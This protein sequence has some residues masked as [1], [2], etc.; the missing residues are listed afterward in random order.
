VTIRQVLQ[1]RSG[2]DYEERYDFGNPGVA[3]R[4][5]E[6]ALVTNQIR[7]ADAARTIRRKHPPGAVWE[8]KT[9]DTAV[10]GWLLERV[11]HGSNLAAFAAQRLW[12][13]LGA[14]HDAFFIMDGPP[15]TGREFSGAGF[16]ATLR[17]LGRVGLMM[18]N[19]GMAGT[20]RRIVSA[21]WVRESTQPTGGPGPGYGYQWW[22]VPDSRAYEALGLQGQYIHVDPETRT[23][24]VKLSY[25]P[26]GRS[27]AEEETAAFFA[28]VARWPAQ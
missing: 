13:P 24:V 2:V 21:A 20:G 11:S 26:P 16:N 12:E 3:A 7:F 17:D 28:A 23:V 10:L 22:T 25:F 18:L 5:H 9:L 27:P 1:M 4:N 19:E 15:G 14:E 6:L 8:Y